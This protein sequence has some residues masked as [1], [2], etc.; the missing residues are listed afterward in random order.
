MRPIGQPGLP[1]LKV[2]RGRNFQ[3]VLPADAGR[4]TVSVTQDADAVE[5]L[6]G[7]TLADGAQL[8]PYRAVDEGDVTIV[9]TSATDSAVRYG[10]AVTI[11]C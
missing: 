9:A 4:V 7:S 5:A 11:T 2:A 6:T 10:V 3:G 1:R 8:L